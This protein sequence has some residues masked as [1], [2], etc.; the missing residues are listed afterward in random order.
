MTYSVLLTALFSVALTTTSAADNS[1]PLIRD[2]E[3][4]TIQSLKS[5]HRKLFDPHS[6]QIDIEVL[7][8]KNVIYNFTLAYDIHKVDL[9][10]FSGI[11]TEERRRKKTTLDV[12]VGTVVKFAISAQRGWLMDDRGI[13]RSLLIRSA[14]VAPTDPHR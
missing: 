8:K 2:W 11:V 10:P 14:S 9:I 3:E 6:A 7:S 5:H 4:G 13:E 12:R 1:Q